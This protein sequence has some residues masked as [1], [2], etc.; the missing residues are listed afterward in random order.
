MEK[1]E[2]LFRYL[3]SPVAFVLLFA[4]GLVVGTVFMIMGIIGYVKLMIADTDLRFSPAQVRVLV[5]SWFL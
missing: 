1:M 3:I 2:V 5:A 4:I